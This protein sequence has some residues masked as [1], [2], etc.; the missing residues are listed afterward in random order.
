VDQA[1]C[2]SVVA[3]DR[4]CHVDSTCFRLNASRRIKG[5]DCSLGI[6]HETVL[7][8]VR[9]RVVARDDPEIIDTV[10]ERAYTSRGIERRDF[11]P[12]GTQKA[13]LYVSANVI[14]RDGIQVIDAPCYSLVSLKIE[15]SEPP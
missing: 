10:R 8:A 13:V 7:K 9:L 4:P 3:R 1:L 6:P 12:R 15:R 11:A 14:A 2:V 5:C